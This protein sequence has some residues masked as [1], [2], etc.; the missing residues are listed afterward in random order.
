MLFRRHY[1][2]AACTFLLLSW[3]ATGCG[4]AETVEVDLSSTPVRFVIDH[5][6]WPRPFW[7]P[8]VTEFAIGSEED[9]LLW[10]L[11][12]TDAS[13]K[14]AH[15]L[16]FVYGEVPPGFTQVFPAVGKAAKSL[17]AGRSYYVGATGPN[18]V[19]RAVFALPIGPEEASRRSTSRPARAADTPI[20]EPVTSSPSHSLPAP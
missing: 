1:V 3:A 8:R 13:G 11:Q 10:Q 18:A 7:W 20:T 9:D 2:R 14:L 17:I 16:A 12:A 15:K 6:G 4:R 5:S 19:Y